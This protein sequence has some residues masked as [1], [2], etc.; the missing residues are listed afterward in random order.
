MPLLLGAHETQALLD[1]L[2]RCYPEEGCGLLVGRDGPGGREVRRVVPLRNRDEAPRDRRYTI[3]PEDFLAV[4]REARRAGLDVV[5]F[6]H[7]H[8]DHPAVPSAFDLE[9]A[10]P[11]YSYVIASLERGRVAECR[12]YRLSDDRARFEPEAVHAWSGAVPA[13]VEAAEEPR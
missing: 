2:L 1:H 10:W 11:Y 7:S 4:E 6:F 13:S 9:H 8:P 3:A 12:A 5:G